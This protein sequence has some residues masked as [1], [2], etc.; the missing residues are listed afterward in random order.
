[1]IKYVDQK[2][3]FQEFPDEI[4]LALNISNCPCNCEGCHSSY[5]ADDIGTPLTEY[6]LEVLIKATKGITCVG[7]MGGDA[8]PEDIVKLAKFIKKRYPNI[9]VGWYSGRDFIADCV[10][11]NIQYFDYIKVGKYDK[12]KGPLNNPNTNQVMYRIV[13][14]GYSNKVDNITYKFWK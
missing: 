4:T 2:V 8:S 14:E 12:D 13:S 7:F 10:N 1:M 6:T 11:S 5:L 3:V 9:K